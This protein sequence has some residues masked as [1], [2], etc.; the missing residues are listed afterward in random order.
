MTALRNEIVPVKELAKRFV[1]NEFISLQLSSPSSRMIE[2]SVIEKR[3]FSKVIGLKIED[4][5]NP[6]FDP[7]KVN[8][9]IFGCKYNETEYMTQT[10]WLF[11]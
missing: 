7:K 8:T 11:E 3:G 10:T 6:R 5:K 1:T 2:K 9:I 4:V